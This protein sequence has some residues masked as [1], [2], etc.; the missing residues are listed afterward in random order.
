MQVIAMQPGF[1]GGHRRRIGDIFTL[2]ENALK[3]VDGKPVLP[4]WVKVVQDASQAKAQVAAVQKADQDKRK[5]GV[6][7]ASG[8]PAAREKADNIAKQLAG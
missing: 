1:S 8:G 5:A 4:K 6:L 3:K 7:A 2:D